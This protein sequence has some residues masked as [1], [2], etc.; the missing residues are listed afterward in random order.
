[1]EVPSCQVIVDGVR[2]IIKLDVGP[3]HRKLLVRTVVFCLSTDP[4]A[5]EDSN[6]VNQ[7]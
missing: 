5:R 4:N 6:T 1:M 7:S 3:L 2:L